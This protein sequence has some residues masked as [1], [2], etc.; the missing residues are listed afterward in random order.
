MAE[1]KIPAAKD[2]I[3]LQAINTSGVAYAPGALCLILIHGASDF[4]DR[5][6]GA[7]STD[8]EGS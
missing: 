7:G 5:V 4:F 8:F 2:R 1:A 3:H 6:A